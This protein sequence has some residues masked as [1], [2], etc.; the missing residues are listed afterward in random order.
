MGILFNKT[1]IIATLG[2]ATNTKEKILQ[3]A[4]A[5][6][7]V[8]R[9][10]FSH[11]THEGHQEVINH[12][13]EINQ[14][15]GLN[16]CCLQDLQGPKIRIGAVEN[17]GVELEE[18]Q[19]FII[20]ID[21]MLGNK[22]M[23]STVYQFLPKDVKIGET[24]LLDDGKI[25][26]IVTG[27]NDRQVFTKVIHGGLLKSK[28]GM[29]LPQTEVSSP[30]LTEK[31]SEDV[32]FGLENNLEWI[33]LSFVRTATDILLLKHLVQLKGKNPKII[34]KIERPEAIENIDEIIKV[35]D[36]IMVARGDL[37]VEMDAELVPLLQKMIV[38]KCQKAAKPVIIATQM[39]ESMINNPRPTRAE[40]N[41]IANAV[42]DGADALMLSAETATGLYPM[43]VIRSMAKTIQYVE[44]RV[45]KLYHKNL[46]VDKNSKTFYS[47]S[48]IAAA[49]NL[50]RQTGA[51]AI[52]G[53]TNS[54][55]TAY[56]L[57][58][59]RPEADIFIFTSNNPLMNTLNL[60]WGVR[61]FFYDKFVSTDTTFKDIIEILKD[62]NYLKEG[63]V[64]IQLASMPIEEKQRTNAI[65]ISIVS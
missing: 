4:Q 56:R 10:N 63:D 7:D 41:D 48:L 39:M 34:A 51:K 28:K 1:K 36:G 9:L 14:E 27:K 22:Q 17:N 44:E 55:Y 33:A 15:Y 21:E 49:C 3:L 46:E 60:V 64:V 18:G 30:S 61:T 54:G 19:D 45:K 65:K 52:V 37:G 2:P 11:G 5:G 24:I 8:F 25:E 43:Q 23:V 50:A 6:V 38:E 12:I 35:A 47:D 57:A 26:L 58:S 59:H 29:N 53:M 62:K 42:V 20:T 32:L 13:R 31:D 16:L 40:T